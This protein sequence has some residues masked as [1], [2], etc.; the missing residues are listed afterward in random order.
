[1]PINLD[2][3]GTNPSLP[4]FFVN[5]HQRMG[6]EMETRNGGKRARERP[7]RRERASNQGLKSK[8]L[9]GEKETRYEG[10]ELKDH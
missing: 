8:D 6:E 4:S 5:Y 2:V 1:M 7:L 9:R 10:C 3:R